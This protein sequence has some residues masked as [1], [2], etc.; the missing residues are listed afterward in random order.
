MRTKIYKRLNNMP[1]GATEDVNGTEVK[2][3]R[4]GDGFVYFVINGDVYTRETATDL[5]AA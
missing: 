5:L 2:K 1:L 4:L 3:L